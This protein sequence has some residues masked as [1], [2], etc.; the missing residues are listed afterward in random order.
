MH[1]PVSSSLS[2]SQLSVHRK[3]TLR[4]RVRVRLRVRL[5]QLR[6]QENQ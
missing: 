3:T 5:R 1:F 2:L 6:L 4:A